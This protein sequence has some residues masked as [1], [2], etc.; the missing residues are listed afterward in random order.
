MPKQTITGPIIKL[1]D[2]L[3]ASPLY[4]WAL[5]FSKLQ[6]VTPTE[7]VFP[8][9]PERG[10]TIQF[11]D[12]IE[13]IQY[14]DNTDALYDGRQDQ[15]LWLADLQASGLETAAR[16]ARDITE[17]WI[18]HNSRWQTNSWRLDVLSARLCNWVS[19]SR[20]LLDG[21][22]QRFSESFTSALAQQALHLRICS[23]FNETL[24]PGFCVQKAMIYVGHSIPGNKRQLERGL[25]LLER[26]AEVEVLAD[27]GHFSRN[28]FAHLRALK[29]LIEIRG[30]LEATPSGPPMWLQG[31]ID[32]MSP[33]LRTYV[34]GDG[35]LAAFNGGYLADAGE[36]ETVLQATRLK[37][38]PATN[39][40]HTGFQRIAARRTVILLDTGVPH[41]DTL[42]ARESA[43]TLSF[44]M[45]VGKQRIIINCGSP[46]HA[47]PS[48]AL[49][50]RGTDAHS[51]LCIHH[52]NSSEI[53]P[54]GK[55]GPRYAKR[56][57]DLRR[58]V[59]KNTLVEAAHDGYVSAFGLTHK[60]ALYL[61]AE[62]NELRG[63]DTVSGSS[64]EDAILRFHLHPS[65][66]ALLVE[67]R[68]SILIKFGKSA[69]WRFKASCSDLTV[70]QSLHYD[71]NTRRQCQQIE[72]KFFHTSPKSVVKWRLTKEH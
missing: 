14:Q 47:N 60:R 46:I 54:D 35:K 26:A 3:F 58:E 28:P 24:P 45:S 42:S 4:A 43:G 48:M 11:S 31:L 33:I 15:F 53:A 56:V 18:A 16:I 36:I 8:G 50:L 7:P 9:D 38:R 39:A 67:A 25:D 51:T 61:S 68:D 17:E 2:T 13:T 69:V 70:S 5:S 62:G 41:A 63:E 40:P 10:R 29:T 64:D 27:G 22:N 12:L 19:A 57:L 72:V 20:F 59:E 37:P 34:M 71:N 32:K 23:Y 44:E 55:L 1:R 21:A 65:V 49:A 6:S 66:Q 30:T 52:T